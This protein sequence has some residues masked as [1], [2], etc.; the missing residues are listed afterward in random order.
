MQKAQSETLNPK[1]TNKA[2][3]LKANWKK[4]TMFYKALHRKL[5]IE[6]CEP[7]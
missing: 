2:D 6:Q 4:K 7:H 5:K 1:K 3:N